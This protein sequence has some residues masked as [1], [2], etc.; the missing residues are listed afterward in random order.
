MHMQT[1]RPCKSKDNRSSPDIL[2]AVVLHLQSFLVIVMSSWTSGGAAASPVLAAIE[3]CTH[4]RA[5]P[6]HRLPASLSAPYCW[7]LPNNSYTR[8]HVILFQQ[9]FLSFFFVKTRPVSIFPKSPADRCKAKGVECS[10]T[11]HPPPN[12]IFILSKPPWGVVSSKTPANYPPNHFGYHTLKEEVVTS[13]RQGAEKAGGI[14]HPVSFDHII[15]CEYS[16]LL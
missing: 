12:P 1:F 5:L 2:P 7:D 10:T 14:P 6:S 11:R 3:L 8:Q 15:F 4:R 9:G 13:F 16:I